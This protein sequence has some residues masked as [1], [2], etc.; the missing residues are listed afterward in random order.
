MR[1]LQVS[2]GL[3][4]QEKGGVEIYTFYLSK[5]LTRLGHSVTIFCREEN[6][7]REEFSLREEWLDGLRVVRVVNNLKK[8]YDP[9]VYYENRYFDEIFTNI[10][11]SLKPDVIHF[12]HF[13]ALSGNLIHL[14]KASGFRTLLSIH[15]F[16]ILCHRINLMDREG[17]L[18]EGPLYGLNCYTCL[19]DYFPRRILSKRAEIFLTLKDL[20]PFWAIKWTKRFFISPKFISQQGYEVF[21]RYRYMF[22][23]LK[24]VDLILLPSSFVLRMYLRYYKKLKKKMELIP[25]G[26]EPLNPSL[27]TKMDEQK[28]RFCY[29]GSILPHKGIH[30]LIEAL[31]RLPHERIHLTLY[32]SQTDWNASYYQRLKESSDG[33]PVEFKDSFD[34]S[35]LSEIL[36][37]QDVVVLPS[38]CPETFSFVIR[39]ANA[40]G[41]PVIGS[42]IGAI[43]EAIRDGMNGFLF[44]PGNI[45]ELT[46]RMLKFI[47]NPKL[48][49]ELR[50]RMKRQKT[51]EEHASELVN[52]YEKVLRN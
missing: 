27:K 47:E 14:A 11:R 35:L 41:I 36:K 37:N 44:Q 48:I 49:F 30:L 34:R 45:K 19:E 4:P 17:R 16:F 18:C 31:K 10:L 33:L 32:G 7:E 38:I 26:I 8:I 43:P 51:M 23:V 42:R 3:P 22:E 24:K 25:W 2:H 46:E 9:K 39:E 28:I 50:R 12:Q 20:L 1:I 29:Y 6:P 52:L 5:A 13:I 40:M 21:H 15:D